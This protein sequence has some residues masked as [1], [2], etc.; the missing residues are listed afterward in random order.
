MADLDK[1]SAWKQ[2]RGMEMLAGCNLILPEYHEAIGPK[3]QCRL[4]HLHFPW[5]YHFTAVH[6][7][8]A[9]IVMSY[10]MYRS[11]QIYDLRFV[12][13]TLQQYSID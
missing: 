7:Q 11:L 1:Q 6:A 13:K 9:I 3:T 4:I 8:Q 10:L 2:M 12:N 5:A